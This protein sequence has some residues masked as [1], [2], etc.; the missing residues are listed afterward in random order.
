M[1]MSAGELLKQVETASTAEDL[2][3]PV[4]HQDKALRSAKRLH[5]A[6]AIH[7]HPDRAGERGIDRTRATNAFAKLGLLYE[8]WAK[9]SD[10]SASRAMA[11]NIK[12]PSRI[13]LT[14][15]SRAYILGDLIAKGTL[16]NVYRA[17]SA[18][19]PVAVKMPRNA[20]SSKFIEAERTAL[21]ALRAMVADGNAWLGPY[22]PRLLDAMTHRA[23]G[24]PE[25]RKVNVLD[26]LSREAGFFS[27]AEV[28]EAI[29]DGLDGRD[30]A[31]IHRRLL[32]AIAG[33]HLAGVVHGA[34]LPENVLIHPAGH[35]VVLAGWSFATR[36]GGMLEGRVQSRKDFYPP[37]AVGG[38]IF[39]ES[40][41]YMAHALM[42][43]MLAPGERRQRAFADGCMQREPRMRPDA[44]SL[45]QEY[46][47]LLEEL[48][49]KRTF[50]VFPYIPAAARETA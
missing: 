1:F 16:A 29:P 23:E 46:D 14:S 27:L 31:W 32:T 13:T 6:Y 12:A 33:A 19:A 4:T 2:F 10:A 40:D 11:R 28:K 22:Y 34:I 49:G 45:L 48:Y 17:E 36:P 47:E 43:S 39:P 50:R 3:G 37:E 7:L 20:S 30:W 18:T 44:A 9:A 25:Q 24:A 15:K 26:D 8:R 42:L 5:R 41:I 35:G 21:T 38:P